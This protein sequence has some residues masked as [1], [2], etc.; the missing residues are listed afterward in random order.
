MSCYFA[1]RINR[2]WSKR[3]SIMTIICWTL[4]KSE[5]GKIKV[6][7]LVNIRILMMQFS[8]FYKAMKCLT[9]IWLPGSYTLLDFSTSITCCYLLSFDTQFQTMYSGFSHYKNKNNWPPIPALLI[10]VGMV[11]GRKQERYQ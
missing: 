3:W 1:W 2:S 5:A 10:A 8:D 9:S 6:G 4:M 7:Y 11:I